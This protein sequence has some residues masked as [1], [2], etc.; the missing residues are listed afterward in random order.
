MRNPSWGFRFGRNCCGLRSCW[1]AAVN[2]MVSGSQVMLCLTQAIESSASLLERCRPWAVQP[3]E[4]T[5]PNL[6]D[7]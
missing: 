6:H 2:G 1:V 4:P 7:L 5:V 3:E